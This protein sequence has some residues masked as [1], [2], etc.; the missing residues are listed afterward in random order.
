MQR[1]VSRQVKWRAGQF[2]AKLGAE[3]RDS[4]RRAH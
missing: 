2:R 1:N 3:P 4:G